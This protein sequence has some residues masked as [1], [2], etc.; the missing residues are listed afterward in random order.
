MYRFFFVASN[1]GGM[2]KRHDAS[3]VCCRELLAPTMLHECLSVPRQEDVGRCQ[4][5]FP[6]TRP[7]SKFAA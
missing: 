7:G 5:V 2:P 1:A 4:L 3:L 6:G